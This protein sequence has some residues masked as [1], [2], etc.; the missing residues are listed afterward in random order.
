MAYASIGF[1]LVHFSAAQIHDNILR[2]SARFAE[3]IVYRPFAVTKWA[4]YF[5]FRTFYVY[6]RRSAVLNTQKCYV[7][8]EIIR[9]N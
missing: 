8:L 9:Q 1:C 3:I 4:F 2:L 5:P 7:R 6:V